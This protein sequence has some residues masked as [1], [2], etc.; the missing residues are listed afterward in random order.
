MQPD[1]T[2]DQLDAARTAWAAMEA[3]MEAAKEAATK[4]ARGEG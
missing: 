3:T 2:A 4:A 1:F